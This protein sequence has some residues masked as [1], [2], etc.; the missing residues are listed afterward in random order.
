MML[1]FHSSYTSLPIVVHY[2]TI[3]HKFENQI[4][5]FLKLKKN[6]QKRQ[7]LNC[8]DKISGFQDSLQYVSDLKA[9]NYRHYGT[10]SSWKWNSIIIARE[11]VTVGVG[12][13][14]LPA[15]NALLEEDGFQLTVSTTYGCIS[16]WELFYI[17]F[18]LLWWR[19]WPKA[20]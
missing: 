7:W 12:S 15:C 8:R 1:T 2:S 16:Y 18:L 9:M 20:I 3:L 13:H 4:Q 11:W 19:S 5:G 17:C 6:K 14:R 10:S